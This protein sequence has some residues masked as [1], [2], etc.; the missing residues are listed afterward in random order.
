MVSDRHETKRGRLPAL[1]AIT[2][3]A[4]CRHEKGVDFVCPLE[5]SAIQDYFQPQKMVAKE[6]EDM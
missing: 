5:K 2:A 1:F 6:G 4:A 3:G